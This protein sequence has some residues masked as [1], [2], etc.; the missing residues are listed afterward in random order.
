MLIDMLKGFYL[1]LPLGVITGLFLF[2]T[3]IPDGKVDREDKITIW[4]SLQKFDL[5]GFATFATAVVLCLLA[6]EWGGT[7]YSWSSAA[8]I[9]LFCGSFVIFGIFLVSQHYKRDAAMVPLNILSNQVV[10]FSCLTV[11]FQMGGLFVLAYY[12]PLWFQVV[13]G[14]TPTFSGLF[15]LP[16]ILSQIAGAIISGSLGRYL[17]FASNR[18]DKI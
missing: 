6:L 18:A 15:I 10:Y 12:L 14:A 2:L 1:N 3:R 7:T 13:K 9:G 16:S 4:K 8:V 5:F 17:V 11:V